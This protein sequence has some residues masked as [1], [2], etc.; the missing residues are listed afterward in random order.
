MSCG[1]CLRCCLD[2][3][4]FRVTVDCR[5]PRVCLKA[6]RD[7]GKSYQKYIWRASDFPQGLMDEA[8]YRLTSFRRTIPS[9][10]AGYDVKSGDNV[11]SEVDASALLNPKQHGGYTN[12]NLLHIDVAAPK[13]NRQTLVCYDARRRS[14][15]YQS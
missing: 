4:R 3:D 6:K 12:A 9:L 11:Q 2:T 15:I 5:D 8:Y 1:E 7:S 13:P 10:E 14:N